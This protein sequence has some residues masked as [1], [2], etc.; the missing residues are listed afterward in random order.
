MLPQSFSHQ[1]A[2][3]RRPAG[4]PV[5]GGTGGKGGVGVE[6]A[7]EVLVVVE[8]GAV[9]VEVMVVLAVVVGAAMRMVVEEPATV[10]VA[11][12]VVVVVV[13]PVGWVGQLLVD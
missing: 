1:R 4:R 10:T 6:G 12:L 8:Q 13:A 9:G 2:H 7:G 3:A 5:T 11:V